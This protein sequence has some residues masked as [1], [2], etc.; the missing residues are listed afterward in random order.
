MYLE[1]A[2]WWPVMTP[3]EAYAEEM[4]YWNQAIAEVIRNDEASLL[5]LGS[6]GG[7]HLYHLDRYQ[8]MV[9]SDLSQPM[10][11]LCAELNPGVECLCLEMTDFSLDRRFDIITVHDSLTYLTSEEQLRGLFRCLIGHLNPGG[12]AL[13]APDHFRDSFDG[14]Y[15]DMTRNIMEDQDLTVLHYSHDPD[16][17]DTTFEAHYVFLEYHRGKLTKSEE[18][19]QL[20]LFDRVTWMDMPRQAGFKVEQLPYKIGEDDEAVLFRIQKPE[21]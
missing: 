1:R 2:D 11:E 13:Y 6:G 18:T 12:I 4:A 19:Q 14:P 8:T 10:L 7:H 9:A 20:G 5:D 16:P 15:A 3:V 17:T 21:E